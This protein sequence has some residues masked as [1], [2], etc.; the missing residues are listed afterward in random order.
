MYE[1]SLFPKYIWYWAFRVI[2]K[3]GVIQKLNCKA[4]FIIKF[5]LLYPAGVWYLAITSVVPLKFW[6]IVWLGKVFKD[7]P[8]PNLKYNSLALDAAAFVLKA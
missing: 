1:K 2:P 8:A 5:V 6:V 7:T 3:F 4:G